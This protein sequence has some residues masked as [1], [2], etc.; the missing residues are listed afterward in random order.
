MMQEFLRIKDLK[1][2]YGTGE[3][4]QDVLRGMDFSVDKGEFCVLIG[5]LLVSVIDY[6][7]IKHIPM[8]VALKNVE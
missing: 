1:K 6:I 5:Y 3:A 2:S 7:R 8:D 4:K